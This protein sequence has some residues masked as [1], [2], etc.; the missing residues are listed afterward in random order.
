MQDREIYKRVKDDETGVFKYLSF[1][2][3]CRG[4]DSELEGRYKKRGV[5]SF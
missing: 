1:F 3:V 2:L 4:N 5:L